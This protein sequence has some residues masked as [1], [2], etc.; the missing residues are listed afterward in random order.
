MSTYR[1]C[2]LMGPALLLQLAG[3]AA[4]PALARNE[5]VH[6]LPCV[7][8]APNPDGDWKVAIDGTA[9]RGS[10][11][12][13]LEPDILDFM[14]VKQRIPEPDQRAAFER[15]IGMFLDDHP[16]GVKVTLLGGGTAFVLPASDSSGHI[17]TVITLTRQ[18][19]AEMGA[20]GAGQPRTVSL[21]VYMAPGD[22]REFVCRVHL[23]PDQGVS[24]IS[25]ID[26]TV[27][28][29][30][31]NN[32]REMLKHTLVDP[33]NPVPGMREVYAA[34]A[35]D[36]VSFHYLSESPGALQETIA[37][38]VS[39]NKYP[40]GTLHLRPIDWGHSHLK[41][42]LSMMDAPPAFKIEQCSAI[43]AALPH[44]R[45]IL[46]G[47][48][49]QHDPEVYGEVARQHPEQVLRILIR[50]VTCENPGDA[51]FAAAFHGVSRKSWQLFRD[52]SEIR[53][54]VPSRGDVRTQMPATTRR[55]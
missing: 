4:F 15:R 35:A 46:I 17:R 50:D 36:G 48:T 21:R 51:R 43:M 31:V 24:V 9:F 7:G 1:G 6:F 8:Y 28:I 27:R 3:C 13:R 34:W 14:D 11:L 53:S 44:R 29:T 42:I 33:F 47:D 12:N 55:A 16:R 23:L 39:R 10:W 2:L 18:Q 54:F 52:P 45:Y 25:D 5:Y 26:D 19:A 40:E 37:E 38:F 49:A 30:D 22:S 41:A 32:T 20:D